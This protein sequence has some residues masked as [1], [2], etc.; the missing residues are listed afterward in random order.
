MLRSGNHVDNLTRGTRQFILGNPPL[1]SYKSV[2][3]L[4]LTDRV[5]RAYSV[6]EGYADF[7]PAE[8]GNTGQTNQVFTGGGILSYRG[9]GMRNFV[10]TTGSGIRCTKF[11]NTSIYRGNATFEKVYPVCGTKGFFSLRLVNTPSLYLIAS[12]PEAGGEV[13]F[14]DIS[15]MVDVQDGACW[16]FDKTGAVEQYSGMLINKRFPGLPLTVVDENT[17][18]LQAPG[19]DDKTRYYLVEERGLSTYDGEPDS[20]PTTFGD[21][22][23]RYGQDLADYNISFGPENLR[24]HEL[25]PV[26]RRT[27]EECAA[28]VA[29]N[30]NANGFVFIPPEL[31]G[32][33]LNCRIKAGGYWPELTGKNEDLARLV[34]G[35]LKGDP[36]GLSYQNPIAPFEIRYGWE[37]ADNNDIVGGS[38]EL[39]QTNVPFAE[40]CA[41]RALREPRANGFTYI[42]GAQNNCRVKVGGYWRT[43]NNPAFKKAVS[44]IIKTPGSKAQ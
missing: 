20:R 30:P 38:H 22:E 19:G 4:S 26:S 28:E 31:S 40:F 39:A 7:K 11:E 1:G 33:G 37:V 34:A 25:Q 8:E 41:A 17:M 5:R 2:S 3:N 9:P 18:K 23:I 36:P 43:N 35:K 12:T 6:N 15:V 42:P 21:F 27:A 24:S 10:N 16:R 13:K 29:K 14:A 44:G 32:D